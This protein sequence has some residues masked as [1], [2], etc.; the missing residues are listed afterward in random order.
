MP[1]VVC[2]QIPQPDV[3]VL[4]L[5]CVHPVSGPVLDIG[6]PKNEK[7]STSFPHNISFSKK[8]YLHS[9]WF[10]RGHP[11]D[12]LCVLEVWLPHL[13]LVKVARHG[14]VAVWI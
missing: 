6:K 8:E 14:R 13:L 1:V 10:P 9:P 11:L 2:R 12:G 4:V 5:P 3:N 7:Y